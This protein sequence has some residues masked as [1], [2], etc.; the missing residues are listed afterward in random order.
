MSRGNTVAQHIDVVDAFARTLH[1]RA[2]QSSPAFADIANGVREL[3]DALRNLRIEATDPDSP[4]NGA[5]YAGKVRPLVEDCDFTLRQLEAVLNH[6]RSDDDGSAA[7]DPTRSARL[8]QMLSTLLLNQ[9]S[10]LNFLN[11]VQLANTRSMPSS[12]MA[13]TRSQPGIEDIQSKVNIVAQRLFSRHTFAGDHDG[14]WR[15][16]QTELEKEGFSR[17]V[18]QK[19]KV[20]PAIARSI[21]Y[22]L[23]SLSPLNF[24]KSSG[25]T[26]A[27]LRPFRHARAALPLLSRGCWSTR[28]RRGRHR[29]KRKCI[30]TWSMRSFRPA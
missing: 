29:R 28:Q 16:F 2:R 19:H 8:S 9:T 22:D 13:L 21:M 1:V 3:H 20:R 4:L 17:E 5:A 7:A 11:T 6:D 18:L 14:L 12:N 23:A 27:S 15:E 30:A 10:I 24:R 25:P 26:F